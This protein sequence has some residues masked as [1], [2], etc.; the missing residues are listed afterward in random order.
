VTMMAASSILLAETPPVSVSDEGV[1]LRSEDGDYVLQLRGTLQLDGR[2]YPG[3]DGALAVDTF[4]IRRARPIFLGTLAR[5]YD[6]NF[7]PD[8]GN[9]TAVIF[10]A[11]LDVHYSPKARVR[12]GKFKPP[13]GLEQL[14]AETAIAFVERSFVTALVPTR[15]VGVQLHGR[16]A[17]G[18]VEYAAGVFNGAPD[19]GGVDADLNDGKDVEGRIFVSPFKRGRSVLKE[20]G[21]G[22]SGTRG[23]QTG[24][25]PAYR[26][27]GQLSI[28]TIVTGT[29]Y[30]GLRTR[31]SPQL[32]YY[33]GPFGLLAEYA[34]SDS[35]AK[36]ADGTRV[37]FA[38]RAWQAT[39]TVALTGDK[40]SYDGLRPRKPF[41]PGK[42]QWG[43]VELAARVN[44]IEL[45]AEAVDGGLV[46]PAKSVRKAFAWA[47]GVN[48]LLNRNLKQ[49]LDYE[50]TTFTG[51]A[52]AG[53]NRLPD[54]AVL[55]RAQIAF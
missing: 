31:Y 51:G 55:M 10:D 26:T 50:R 4:V 12:A 24:P 44:G 28:V 21:F 8:F 39:A 20:L 27:N 41:D 19:G 36:R 42:G 49:M 9:G 22:I 14:Q 25:L 47:I 3:G 53:G 30:D 45:G 2:F 23:D 13:V 52:P 54:N 11:Y 1:F 6:F 15:D 18:V 7:T 46:D 16:L 35:R 43:A 37:S 17:G 33:A 40:A 29:T 38:A 48:W 32:S 5:Y 34:A